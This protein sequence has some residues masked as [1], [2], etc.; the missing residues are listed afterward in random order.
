MNRRYHIA[1]GLT[2]IIAILFVVRALLFLHPSPGDGATK[3][4][5]RFQNVDKISPGSRVTFAGKPVGEVDQ[6]QLL[7]EVFDERTHDPRPLYSYEVLLS[8]DSSVKVYTSDE[9]SVKTAGLMGE[10]FIAITPKP[11]PEGAKLQLIGPTDVVFAQPTGSAEETIQEIATV[12]LKADETMDA[13][14]SLI[15]S[16]EV[17]IHETAEAIRK[18]SLQLDLLLTTLNNGHIGEKVTAVA[19]KSLVCL[20]KIDAL[21]TSMGGGS[22]G[23]G[24]LAKLVEDPYLYDNLLECSQRTNQLIADIN[25]YGVFF[26]TN[27]DWQREMH[28]RSEEM[29][30]D[31]ETPLSQMTRDRFVKI[32]QSMSE[33]NKTL[34]QAKSAQPSGS[35]K[36]ERALRKEFSKGLANV[37]QQIDNLSEAVHSLSLGAASDVADEESD[38]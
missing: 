1:I 10:H 12:A 28:R 25:T 30:A 38:E 20:D 9:I 4:H 23:E 11:V 16:N 34:A 35:L 8:I 33:L 27:R 2:V 36:D 26:H 17:S 19:D 18:A 32:T 24:T 7:Q 22:K 5:V 14:S 29:I 21:T 37:Q 15:K 6:V 3:L 13:L 31:S